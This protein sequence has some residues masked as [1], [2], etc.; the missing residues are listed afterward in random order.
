MKKYFFVLVFVLSFYGFAEAATYDAATCSLASINTAMGLATHGDTVNVPAGNCTWD[1]ALEITKAIHLKGAGM[2]S[3]VI[4]SNLSYTTNT[5]TT[6]N[7]YQN[8]MIR[9]PTYK[10]TYASDI[11]GADRA[12]FESGKFEVSNMT[13]DSNSKSGHI[14]MQ[15]PTDSYFTF[16]I[17]DVKFLDC[18]N[19]YHSGT[20]WNNTIRADGQWNGLIS[21][22]EF[23][24][25]PFFKIPNGNS[26]TGG[27]LSLY[28]WKYT[29]HLGK[30]QAIY[31]E[32]N[33][34]EYAHANLLLVRNNADGG[35]QKCND[36]VWNL[37]VYKSTG[38]LT[39]G[40]RYMVR[41]T[42]ANNYFCASCPV[43]TSFTASSAVA[44][45]ASN[46]VYD[47]TVGWAYSDCSITGN[48]LHSMNL[49]SA[50]VLRYNTVNNLST[51]T[52]GFIYT[53]SSRGYCTPTTS[54]STYYTSGVLDA[55]RLYT[56][57][58]T[59]ASN[60]FCESCPVGTMFRA[61]SE[62]ALSA[63]NSVWNVGYGCNTGA[64]V[65]EAYGN[66]FIADY[67]GA[68][69]I[70]FASLEDG[71]SILVNNKL[72]TQK[73]GDIHYHKQ[74]PESYTTVGRTCPTNTD[75]AFMEYVNPGGYS[76]SNDT[77]PLPQHVHRS[78]TVNN[79]FGPDS[80]GSG[81]IPT[82]Y[83]TVELTPNQLEPNI[84]YFNHDSV[85]C[86]AGGACTAGVGCG[87][88]LPTTATKGV[89]FWLT[90]QSC[91]VVQAGTY[92][93][94]PSLPVSGTLYRAT[95]TNTWKIF[96]TP[97]SY[98][99]PLRQVADT[100]T[101][102]STTPTGTQSCTGESDDYTIGVTASSSIG[103][104]G[105]NACLENGT[106]CTSET[107]YASMGIS[108]TQSGSNWTTTVTT[109]CN[110]TDV[111]YNAKCT[112]G[113]NV[114]SN[115]VIAYSTQ[116]SSDV[117]NPTLHG[118][119]VPVLGSTGRNLTI[120]FSE[121]VQIGAGGS[122]GWTFTTGG[123]PVT[124]NYKSGSGTTAL[125]YQASECIVD[126]TVLT[127]DFAQ[128]TDGIQD[129]SGNILLTIGDAVSVTNDSVET[130]GATTSL[131]STDIPTY[132]TFDYA[133]AHEGGLEFQSSTAEI[134]N[135][136]CFYKDA[137]MDGQTHTSSLWCA[138]TSCGGA[139]TLIE[140]ITHTGEAESGWI[141]SAL[142]TPY[143]ILSGVPYRVSLWKS[144]G[145]GVHTLDYFTSGYSNDG[146]L[147]IAANG[148]K[149]VDAA[150]TP[151]YPNLDSKRNYW[152]DIVLAS[153]ATGPWEVTTN[154]IGEGCYVTSEPTTSIKDEATGEV[155][156]L[157]NPGWKA[158]FTGTCGGSAVLS[159]Y[160]YTYTTSAVEADCTVEAT[161]SEIQRVPWIAP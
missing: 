122:G 148:G 5:Y 47:T 65:Y 105:C 61:T 71:V 125:V 160:T 62:L 91:D 21:N 1:S 102:S 20:F 39:V 10:S 134:V 76:C 78:Y 112:N 86:V 64:L 158:T 23:Y 146:N 104:T 99:H 77:I 108:L 128:V 54:T 29:D 110:S 97:F 31:I 58:T 49:S 36:Y 9:F 150:V 33:Y 120:T 159:G 142:V 107:S 82:P 131:F 155:V 114:S 96:W 50:A 53:H 16:Y 87:S 157:V 147:S 15:N 89:G 27:G 43:G 109:N 145:I 143:S 118:S 101:I 94:N 95:D 137:S 13:L 121:I 14:Y 46:T 161:C 63:S 126:D 7:M 28:N 90:N 59:S 153:G 151:T 136:L 44:C 100:P 123:N 68:A 79:R 67:A 116:S 38:T 32:D 8:Y 37:S 41:T 66:Y 133:D 4:T 25:N 130:C 139:G 152:V 93:K 129:A 19:V 115:A 2:T 52:P 74:H 84:H 80:D 156:L 85:N 24:G 34:F 81:T 51:R 149:R 35:P 22:N 12:Y 70:G 98:P 138:S 119:T 92:G 113:T 69:T 144:L 3:T 56:V 132:T 48:S 75:P 73:L 26:P 127:L 30:D 57:R 103:V 140:S 111:K 60:Y 11:Y 40:K 117:T 55:G 45:D 141:C 6:T 135:Q 88:T 106:T 83:D 72:K 18:I 154:K 42:S 17:H 124:I